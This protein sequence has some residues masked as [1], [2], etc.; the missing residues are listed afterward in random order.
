VIRHLFQAAEEF[1]FLHCFQSRGRKKKA[2]CRVFHVSL[3]SVRK[4]KAAIEVS[5][6]L[7]FITGHSCWILN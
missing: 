2:S 6:I 3:Q 1:L 4:K 7:N 5:F